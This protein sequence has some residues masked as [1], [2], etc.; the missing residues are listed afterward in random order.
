[1]NIYD[2][3]ANQN[4]A[5]IGGAFF[6]S[7]YTLNLPSVLNLQLRNNVASKFG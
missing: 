5:K 1:M 7:N 3:E 4:S 6:L 2:S